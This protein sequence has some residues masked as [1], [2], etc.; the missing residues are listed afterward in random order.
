MSFQPVSFGKYELVSR[1]AAGGMAEI[2]LARTKGIQ[3]FEKYLVIKR[4]LGHRTQD[5][6]FVR[7]FLDEAR[8]AATL[9]HPNIVQIYDVGHVDNEYFIAM[10]YLR[11]HN[12]IE[13]V[14]AGAKLGYAKPPLEHVVSILTQC[15]AGL[16]YAHDKRDFEGRS[17]EI[18]HRDVTPQNVVVSF[19]GSV[20]VVDFGIAKAATREVETLA[21]TLKGKIGYMS[22]EQCRGAPVDRRSDIF[23]VGII[24][25]ELTTG[26]RLYHERSD[27]DTLKKIIE[28]PVPSPR[29]LLPFYPA[30][31]NAIVVR[32]LQKN[33]DDRYQTARDL[34][35]DLD[36]FGRD[37]QLV[38]GTVPLSQYMERI[39][40]DE[41]ATH[42]SADAAAMATAAQVTM[43]GSSASY[44]GE[45]S[46]RTS[47]PMATP[48]AEAR[49]QHMMRLGLQATIAVLLVLLGGGVVFWQT[50][51]PRG[52]ATT[53]AAVPAAQPVAAPAPGA[54]A[55]PKTTAPGVAVA[56][57]ATGSTVAAAPL[58]TTHEA[59]PKPIAKPGD[60]HITVAS[61]PRCELLVDGVP[62]GNTPLIDLAVPAGKHTIVLLNSA[63][64]I[65]ESKKVALREGELWTRSF[66]FEGGK[67]SEQ[68]GLSAKMLAGHDAAPAKVEAPPVA[69]VTPKAPTPAPVAKPAAPTPTAAAS[70]P[71]S[72]PRPVEGAASGGKPAP[73]A[74]ASMAPAQKPKNVAARMLDSQQILHPD[75]LLPA[76]VRSQRKGTGDA[77]FAAK[78]CVN[79]DGKVYQVNVLSSIPGADDAIVNTIKQWSYKPQPVSVC[80]VANI[81]YDLQ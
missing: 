44:L 71:G 24:L 31:L 68:N 66:S 14:R 10:E 43:T 54:A 75:P 62:Y 30:F 13:I 27:F 19:D 2:F 37:N 72:A 23:A 21:G 36:A 16:H 74:V 9:D 32:C 5:P 6:E 45:S 57:P 15:C 60:G 56:A 51:V 55:A 63:A 8:V 65:R 70:A 33:P 53:T 58:P 81:V 80:F 77:R 48:L 28:G 22:P 11:G 1:L 38:T 47:S 52:A 59:R 78:V 17:L 34:H 26:K 67:A 20:K 18:V 39:Y 7:M 42:K 4:I 40:A 76:I 35:A 49:R 3:G 12:L 41:L 61:E 29:D 46:R 79:N 64:N 73:T 69:A 50:R 25:F